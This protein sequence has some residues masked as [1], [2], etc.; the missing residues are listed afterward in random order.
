MRVDLVG[1]KEIGAM[2]GVSSQAVGNWLKRHRDFPKPI[3]R[4]KMGP[5]FDAVQVARWLAAKKKG[6]E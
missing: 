1:L 5:I 2:A 3:A 4:L 6:R